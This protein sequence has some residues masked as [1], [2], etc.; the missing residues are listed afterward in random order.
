MFF[1][2]TIDRHLI[3][4]NIPANKIDPVKPI[5]QFK[6]NNFQSK[7]FSTPKLQAMKVNGDPMKRNGL[8]PIGRITPAR[9][10]S[11]KKSKKIGN[12]RVN[13]FL[14]VYIYCII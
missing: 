14:K 1:L 8:I 9:F 6:S 11:A 5:M 3:H 2:P 7:N 10:A 12:Q 4:A 13:I